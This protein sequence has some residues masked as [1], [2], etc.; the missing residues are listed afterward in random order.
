MPP[1]RWANT[2]AAAIAKLRQASMLPLTEEG[3]VRAIDLLRGKTV[4]L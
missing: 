4:G 1:K 2:S 3:L